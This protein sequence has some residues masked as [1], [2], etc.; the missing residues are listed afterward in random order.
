VVAGAA[1]P[2]SQDLGTT[3]FVVIPDPLRRRP[4][5]GAHIHPDP[6]CLGR[7]EKRRAFGRALRVVGMIDT[8]P[9]DAYVSSEHPMVDTHPGPSKVG[10]P[11]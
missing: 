4:G 10:R 2:S 3:V 6:S 8:G 11:T 1:E 7:A 9:L 5:R